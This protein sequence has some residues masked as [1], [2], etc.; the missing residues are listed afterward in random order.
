MLRAPMLRRRSAR[1]RIRCQGC[2]SVAICGGWRAISRGPALTGN[3]SARS[4]PEPKLIWR[5]KPISST[6]GSKARGHQQRHRAAVERGAP[7][8]VALIDREH[9]DRPA[10]RHLGE[11][12]RSFE[13]EP[14]LHARRID[15]PAR[16]HGDVLLTVDRKETGTPFTPEPVRN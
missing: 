15:A 7:G 6:S 4:L 11:L 14:R 10:L 3:A 8:F 2:S 16:L 9:P 1:R 5:R 12:P 13:V